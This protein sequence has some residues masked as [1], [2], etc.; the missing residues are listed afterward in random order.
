[1]ETRGRAALDSFIESLAAAPARVLLLDFDG[2]LAPY[3]VERDQTAPYEGV[4]DAVKSILNS[5]HT[6]VVVISGREVTNLRR[7]LG[8]EPPPELWGT[9]GWERM[10][11]GGPHRLRTVPRVAAAALKRA[12]PALSGLALGDRIEI[13][14]AS[15]AIHLRGLPDVERIL[16][17]VQLAWEPLAPEGV[18]ILP[19]DGGVEL[20]V[21][22]WNKG[23]AVRAVLADEPR[24]TAVAYLGDD[25]SDEDAFRALDELGAEGH[26]RPLG[27]MVRGE[28]RETRAAARLRPPDEMLDFLRRWRKATH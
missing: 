28:A 17:A 1:M 13:K 18:E 16:S 6:R 11:R 12:G 24:G 2:T 10:E 7:L 4:R 27:V 21:R 25:A 9:H 3:H 15:L 20:R 19:F 26:V 22:G 14:P 8:I 5:H 23:D